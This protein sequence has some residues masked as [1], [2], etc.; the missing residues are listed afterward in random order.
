[1][2]ES[3]ILTYKTTNTGN[4]HTEVGNVVK[5]IEFEL[6]LSKEKE[7]G[8]KLQRMLEENNRYLNTGF[9]GSIILCPALT[10][11]NHHKTAVNLLLNEAYPE[12][13]YSVNLGATTVW[14]RWNSV[15]PDGKMNE[16]GMNS[17][18]HYS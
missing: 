17:L 6:M 8:Q 1:M 11:T 4:V 18:N 7:H 13:L 15:M 2:K 10:K 5:D 9:V 14:E 3:W 12:W 16:E